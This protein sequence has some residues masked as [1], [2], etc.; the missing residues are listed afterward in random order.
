MAVRQVAQLKA[1]AIPALLEALRAPGADTVRFAAYTLGE[2]RAARSGPG[3]AAAARQPGR[4]NPAARRLR[5]RHDPRQGGHRRADRR[6]QGRR[7]GR[8][9]L[10]R[11][12]AR[13]DRRPA[14]QGGPARGAAHRG[15][16]RRQHGDLALQPRQ[17]GGRRDPDREAARPEP[18]QP[19]LRHLRAR[20]DLRPGDGAPADRGARHRGDRLAR[21]QGARQ[22]RPAGAAAAARVALLREPHR[23]TLR[24]LRARRDPRPQ[25]RP[26]GAAAARRTRTRS[27]W[28]P[29]PRR[30]S[31][32]ASAR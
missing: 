15:R 18:E 32:S 7:S 13:R 23:A 28:T 27:C 29:P 19:P 21:G 9:R 5:A 12:G 25:G 16:L 3:A 6:A 22:H 2:I 24:H 1:A 30:W 17:P 14:R 20:Q 4:R 8:P 26:R 10:R 31:P 11:D